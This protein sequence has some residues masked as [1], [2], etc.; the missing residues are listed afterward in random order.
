MV[1]SMVPTDDNKITS[2][3]GG[4]NQDYYSPV[5]V[6][7]SLLQ[8][9]QQ[10]IP[11][12]S[13]DPSIAAVPAAT[14]AAA[15][16]P[17][18]SRRVRFGSVKTRYYHQIL[19]DH[20]LC[21]DGLPITF[22]WTWYEDNEGCSGDSQG[23]SNTQEPLVL[24][25][26]HALL[27]GAP[28]SSQSSLVDACEPMT[29]TSSDDT[30]RHVP[31]RKLSLVT[32]MALLL[33]SGLSEEEIAQRIRTSQRIRIQLRRQEHRAKMWL[34]FLERTE[35]TLQSSWKVWSFDSASAGTRPWNTASLPVSMW[36]TSRT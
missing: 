14:A 15:A 25:Q 23:D 8:Q 34:Q 31:V 4:T 5:V 3:S 2:T 22:G 33:E 18:S 29:Q 24:A 26:A 20:P 19:G 9:Q 35:R 11:V 36:S 30:C 21:A 12:L 7:E 28:S 1:T 6:S 17:H 32:R 27:T 13:N 16:A 10:P